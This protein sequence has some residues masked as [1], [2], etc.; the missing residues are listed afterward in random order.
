MV[1]LVQMYVQEVDLI[2]WFANMVSLHDWNLL[3]SQITDFAELVPIFVFFAFKIKIPN[4]K[5]LMIY[6]VSSLLI[7]LLTF[8]FIYFTENNNTLP[9]YH[10]LALTEFVLLY[11][12]YIGQIGK[13]TYIANLVLVLVVLFNI[14]NT[15]FLQNLY[16]FNSYAWTVNTIVLIIMGF[17]YLVHL[18]SKEDVV[19]I[20]S[21]PHFIINAGLLIYLAG[22]LFT[23]MLGWYILSQKP[24]GFFANGWI[25]QS[26]STI[27]KNIIIAFGLW[28]ARSR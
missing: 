7:K 26:I 9:Y 8:Y 23:Y 2:P 11:L 18:Y 4:T 21:Y 25:I 19:N 15:L 6:L 3:F 22:S 10:L 20:V 28:T 14:Y 27:L 5:A 13:S 24:E 16:Q 1:L 17:V 12:Y